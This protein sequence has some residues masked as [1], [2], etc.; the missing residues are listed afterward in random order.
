MYP[1]FPAARVTSVAIE[2]A[3]PPADLAGDTQAAAYTHAVVT[4]AYATDVDAQALVSEQVEPTTQS[5][6]LGTT[7][8]AWDA[9]PTEGGQSLQPDEA[10]VH[11][12]RGL[13]YI[14]TLHRATT[15][16]QPTLALI[17]KTNLHAVQAINLGL[18]FPPQTLLYSPPKLERI[19][20][21][22]GGQAWRIDYRFRYRPFSWNL[23]WRS[24]AAMY[25]PIFSGSGLVEFYPPADFS[26]LF[27]AFAS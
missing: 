10:P 23:A 8:L 21:A 24:A 3:G 2:P 22:E 12:A 25:S 26:E 11:I 15:I 19:I 14:L 13:D 18:I 27:T 20:T 5:L 4:V 17:R 7:G 16:P 6:T 9:P 1:H